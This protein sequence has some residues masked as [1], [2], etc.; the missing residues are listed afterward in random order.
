MGSVGVLLPCTLLHRSQPITATTAK[1][2]T[3]TRI[4]AKGSDLSLLVIMA[5][6][7]IAPSPIEVEPLGDVGLPL[8][9]RF[10]KAEMV[11]GRLAASFC[12]PHTMA[13]M[14]FCETVSGSAL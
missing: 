1:H 8:A 4:L 13:S 3:A 5:S 12:K 2:A 9:K 6:V 10:W 14:V 11:C 7:T